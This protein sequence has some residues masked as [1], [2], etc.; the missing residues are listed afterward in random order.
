MARRVG[1]GSQFVQSTLK[2]VF[3]GR[4]ADSVMK[5]VCIEQQKQRTS[6][7]RVRWGSAVFL[8]ASIGW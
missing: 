4:T 7:L 3:A 8:C 5:M 2:G 1:E 6:V